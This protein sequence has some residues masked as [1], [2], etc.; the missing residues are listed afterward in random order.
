MVRWISIALLSLSLAGCAGYKLGPSNGIPAG[1]RSVQV[2]PF[3]NA[4]MEPRLIEPLTE[5][6]RRRLQQ[7]GTYR[8]DTQGD[9]DLIVTGTITGYD[10]SELSFQPNDILTVRD[11]NLRMFAKVTVTE[12]GT[13][14]VI[15]ERT[16][17]GR[18]VIRVGSDQS[19]AERQAIPILAADLARNAASAITDGSW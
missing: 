8:L 1:S 18:T 17:F 10:R 3:V 7:D 12:R 4:T 16:V 2:N 13:G 9:G 15:L 19:S 5:A 11:Y 14:K 6:L